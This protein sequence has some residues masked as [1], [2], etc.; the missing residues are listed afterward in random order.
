MVRF[1]DEKI[2]E[3]VIDPAEIFN[4]SRNDSKWKR[5]QFIMDRAAALIR[6][7]EI[8]KEKQFPVVEGINDFEEA[9]EYAD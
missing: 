1:F 9:E 8:I 7:K 4:K 3:G 6:V 5:P 2:R